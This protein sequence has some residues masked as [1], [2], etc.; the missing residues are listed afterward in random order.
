ML[1]QAATNDIQKTKKGF[2]MSF[3]FTCASQLFTFSYLA[4][5]QSKLRMPRPAPIVPVDLYLL[6]P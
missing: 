3:S 4:Q 6:D 5:S 1:I 2:T